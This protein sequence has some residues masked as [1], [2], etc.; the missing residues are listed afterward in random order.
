MC[1]PW[2]KAGNRKLRYEGTKHSRDPKL[3][4]E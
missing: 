2:K 3:Y 1:S 4:E